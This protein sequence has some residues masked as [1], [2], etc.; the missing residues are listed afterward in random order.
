MIAMNSMVKSMSSIEL[1][2]G[3]DTAALDIATSTSDVEKLKL[4]ASAKLLADYMQKN[5]S[6]EL[7]DATMQRFFK[8]FLLDSMWQF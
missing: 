4:E 1:G 5:L 8:S 7:R 6:F 2:V 3:D